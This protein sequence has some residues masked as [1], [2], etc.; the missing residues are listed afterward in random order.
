MAFEIDD[1]V[2]VTGKVLVD[3]SVMDMDAESGTVKKVD[4]NDHYYVETQ[5]GTH[6]VY[7]PQYLA[8]D[9]S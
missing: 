4:R 3:D 1:A 7:G 9:E 2:L 6:Y 8:P 5:H